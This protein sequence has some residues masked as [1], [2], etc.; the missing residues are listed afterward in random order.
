MDIIVMTFTLLN[1]T[2]KKRRYKEQ[3]MSQWAINYADRHSMNVLTLSQHY[4]MIY[5]SCLVVGLV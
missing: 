2:K 5:F 1:N 3:D 4:V